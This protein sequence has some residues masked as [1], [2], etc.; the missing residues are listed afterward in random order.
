MIH[1]ALED[2]ECF[3]AGIDLVGGWPT[4]VDAIA[5]GFVGCGGEGDIGG[6]RDWR[7]RR[8]GR[9]KRDDGRDQGNQDRE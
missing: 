3:S 9:L 8:L 1:I 6:L 7:L 5:A 2:L 4:V